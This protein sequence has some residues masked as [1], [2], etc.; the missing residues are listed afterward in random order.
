MKLC[1]LEMEHSSDRNSPSILLHFCSYWKSD[2]CTRFFVPDFSNSVKLCLDNG[3]VPT[4][5]NE[6]VFMHHSKK[7]CCETHF[8]FRITQCMG[9]EHILY[10][11]DSEKCD[12]KMEFDDWE[13]KFTLAG[14]RS[15]GLFETL[16]DCCGA[17]FWWDIENCMAISPNDAGFT[18]EFK[19]SDLKAPVSCQE[20]DEIA[21]GWE[22]VIDNDLSV[23]GY[24]NVTTIGCASL[25]KNVETGMTECG[26]CLANLGY[27][28]T[29]DSIFT[30]GI[31]QPNSPW[32]LDDP[33]GIYHHAH[34]VLTLV[35]V[36]I[37]VFSYEFK[38]A[39]E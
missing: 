38:D 34:K 20:A 24:S 31:S 29:T 23:L 32:N 25:T 7:E 27:V 13:S 8:W 39:G 5:S 19:L 35:T 26:G 3:V 6:D 15:S 2:A 16:E 21:A 28:G 1:F 9:N 30:E 36:D 11:S 37:R 14:W 17:S 33:D 10:Y 18:F 4:N 12:I 22:H